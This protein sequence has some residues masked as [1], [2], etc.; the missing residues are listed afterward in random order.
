MPFS[1]RED[2]NTRNFRIRKDLDNFEHWIL[3]GSTFEWGENVFPDFDLVVFLQIPPEIR[4]ER[5]RTR[6]FERYGVAIFENHDRKTQF[7]KF[8]NWAADYDINAGIANRNINA[9]QK[10]LASINYSVLKIIG[11]LTT[12][13]RIEHI[14]QKLQ[15]EKHLP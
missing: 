11:D 13:N 10:R 7:D 4:I 5:L 3:G 14:I 1:I 12:E 8:I 6:E 15:Q 2:K 9:H